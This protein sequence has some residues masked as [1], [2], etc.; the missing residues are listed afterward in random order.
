MSRKIL[1]RIVSILVTLTLCLGTTLTAFAAEET[2]FVEDFGVVDEEAGI[3]PY[4]EPLVS[5]VSPQDL[6]NDRHVFLHLDNY[7]SSA[8]FEAGIN[9]NPGVYYRVSVHTPDNRTFSTT[10]V[11]DGYMHPIVIGTSAPAGTY[12]F[13]F[14]RQGGTAVATRAAAAIYD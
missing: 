14:V 6:V 8:T 4:S 3:I 13:Y 5:A 9:I 7:N 12:D 10:I 1:N 2:T 11:A